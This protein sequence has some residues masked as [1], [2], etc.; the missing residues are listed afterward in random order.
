M[1]QRLLRGETVSAEEG[2][3]PGTE[4]VQAV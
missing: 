3:P 1:V 4:D 2:Y